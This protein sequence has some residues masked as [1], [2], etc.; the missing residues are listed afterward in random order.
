MWK[1]HKASFI[2]ITLV[3]LQNLL[4][5]LPLSRQNA[6]LSQIPTQSHYNMITYY[7]ELLMWWVW[8]KA[9]K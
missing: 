1:A 3:R 9:Q 4:V 6:L 8:C 7:V 5:T 2:Q